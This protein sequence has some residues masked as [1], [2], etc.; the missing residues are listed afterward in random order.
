MNLEQVVSEYQRLYKT[1][2]VHMD[3]RNLINH[4][5]E[6]IKN[7][8]KN[9]KYRSL[10]KRKI[11]TDMTIRNY[12][13]NCLRQ[14]VG[15][16]PLSLVEEY[17]K[18]NEIQESQPTPLPLQRNVYNKN[19][20]EKL[21]MLNKKINMLEATIKTSRYANK[22]TIAINKKNL[23]DFKNEKIELEKKNQKSPSDV[24]E[25]ESESETETNTGFYCTDCN[26]AMVQSSNGF[27]C[28]IC[29][30]CGDPIV[31]QSFSQSGNIS[32]TKVGKDIASRHAES[33]SKSKSEGRL[34]KL[35]TQ[36]SDYFRTT[37]YDVVQ[38]L[39]DN[40]TFRAEMKK[41]IMSHE[42][43]Q[44]NYIRT[45]ITELI[46]K[47]L[48]SEKF[49]LIQDAL[50]EMQQYF[51]ITGDLSYL[52]PATYKKEICSKKLQELAPGYKL[53][54]NLEKDAS[55]I[56]NILVNKKNKTKK[57]ATKLIQDA[58][59]LPFLK[60]KNEYIRIMNAN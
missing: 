4:F 51:V 13:F 60:Y 17:P 6:K 57:D 42:N 19:D 31:R 8:S 50:K 32:G 46:L 43:Y 35:D 15:L 18:Y 10:K 24:S 26:K 52:I 39:S 54:S 55:A 12:F 48:M 38:R 3:S 30:I 23:E 14:S 33:L 41:I 59:G 49:D 34:Q 11:I 7:E 37:K 27:C 5:I 53:T 40:N 47:Y 16:T 44:V 25:S 21:D 1:D 58:C 29:G 45:K 28:E 22:E 56:L 9:K 20:Q 2:E 36:V